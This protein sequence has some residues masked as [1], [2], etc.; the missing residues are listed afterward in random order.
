MLDKLE[1][2]RSSA[3]KYIEGRKNRLINA[4]NFYDGRK[5]IINAFN[6]K[7]FPLDDPSD[8]TK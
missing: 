6:N 8:F 1:G 3:P 2:C 7:T 5:I 4:Q